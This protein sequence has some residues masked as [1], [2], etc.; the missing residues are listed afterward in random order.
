[1]H[2]RK[3][4]AMRILSVAAMGIVL[5]HLS[6]LATGMLLCIG[7]GTA[8][9]CCSTRVDETKKLLDGSDCSCCITVHAA[10]STVGATSHKASL[11]IVSNSR[12]LQ[13]A[14]SPTGTCNSRA[15]G[16]DPGDSRLCSLRA[17]VL[18]I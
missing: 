13:D 11:D 8:P 7:D 2:M 1:M 3:S 5:A 6:P 17:V 16:H 4:L 18:L 12:P 10:P 9:D 15:R 14:A